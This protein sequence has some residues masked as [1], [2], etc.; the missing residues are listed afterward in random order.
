MDEKRKRAM[1]T[2][3]IIGAVTVG[4]A[5]LASRTPRDKWKITLVR[6]AKDGVRLARSRYRAVAP[7]LELA[8]HALSHYEAQLSGLEME[9]KAS[10]EAQS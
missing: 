2:G 4:L 3:V 9:V 5:V 1:T 10:A 6:V 7:L 8:E